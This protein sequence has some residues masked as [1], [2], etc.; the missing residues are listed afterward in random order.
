MKN[1]IFDPVRKKRV[2]YTPEESVRQQLIVY[3][4]D[5]LRYPQSHMSCEHSLTRG[6]KRYRSDLIIFDKE[7]KPY[8]LAECKAPGVKLTADVFEQIIRYN[9]SLK[10]KYLMLTNGETSYFAVYDACG[11]KYD[12]ITEMPEF[13]GFS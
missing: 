5:T 11:D 13:N 6:K 1:S 7:L 3:L 12:F 2:A 10:V 9:H 8:L 4:R